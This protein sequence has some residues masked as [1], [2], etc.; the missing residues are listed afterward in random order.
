MYRHGSARKITR[1]YAT[2]RSTESAGVAMATSSGRQSNSPATAIAR[3]IAAKKLALVPT[4]RRRPARL[5]API[6][7]R[8]RMVA[9]GATTTLIGQ[10]IGA[11][12]LAETRRV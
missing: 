9:P 5:W 12:T 1:M 10:W 11:N 2:E 3:E 7:G 4:T 6:D 8:R